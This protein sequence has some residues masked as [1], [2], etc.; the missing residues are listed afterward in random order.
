M[1]ART[2]V[3]TTTDNVAAA[4]ALKDM[5]VFARAGELG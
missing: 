1:K 3:L 5:L 2:F 4:D